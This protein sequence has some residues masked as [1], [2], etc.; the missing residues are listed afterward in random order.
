MG[1]LTLRRK[2]LNKFSNSQTVVGSLQEKR[3]ARGELFGY[4][5]FLCLAP[6][7][8]VTLYRRS[9]LTD[10]NIS[11]GLSAKIIDLLTSLYNVFM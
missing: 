3:W 8:E 5:N 4:C 10:L 1:L 11:I 6:Q 7:K 9:Q 2:A